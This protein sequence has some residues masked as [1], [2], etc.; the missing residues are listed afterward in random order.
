MQPILSLRDL[1]SRV[2][3][4]PRELQ[5]LAEDVKRHYREF[6]IRNKF[7]PSIVRIVRAPS[8]VLKDVQ[9]RIKNNVLAHIPLA[10]ALHGG[11]RGRSPASNANAHLGQACVVKLD[12]KA[13]FPSI[14][15][16]TVY[17]MFKHE[18]GFGRDVASV[19]TKLTTVDGEL[20]QG[21]PTST[22][23]ANIVL[24]RVVDEPVDRAAGATGA[25]YTRFVDDVTLSG[26]NPR[27]LINMVGKALS[28]RGLHMYRKKARFEAQ[29]KLRILA[30]GSAQE[31]TGL[32]VNRQTGPSVARK[33]RDQ[34]RAAIWAARDEQ[35]AAQR[36][37]AL[38]SLRGK[39]GHI[40]RHNPGAADRLERFLESL[41]SAA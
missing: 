23:I 14:S 7:N 9:S 21:A 27:P 8:P 10:D 12:V 33:R 18:L 31:V 25:R 29:S 37:K 5:K 26:E 4:R 1:C 24:C 39:I 40:R 19:L 32:I 11:V 30:N 34:V 20:P 15:H 22:A 13:F 17:R 35:D 28:R 36:A 38:A 3:V 41:T 16:R 2:G 6:G